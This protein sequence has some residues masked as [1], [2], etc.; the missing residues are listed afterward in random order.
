MSGFF[1]KIN[2]WSQNLQ[3]LANWTLRHLKGSTTDRCQR[4][5]SS[6]QHNCHREQHLPKQPVCVATSA[7]GDAV[8]PFPTAKLVTE[9]LGLSLT[10]QGFNFCDRGFIGIVLTVISLFCCC[11]CD[12][13]ANLRLSLYWETSR[14]SSGD[15]V[16]NTCPFNA[17]MF[18]S[19]LSAADHHQRPAT[20][21]RLDLSLQSTLPSS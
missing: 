4:D 19:V 7:C 20:I 9:P 8:L 12:S 16:I 2:L 21:L 3:S 6:W 10:P 5:V 11:C 17:H 14:V 13:A 1:P 15:W 18:S